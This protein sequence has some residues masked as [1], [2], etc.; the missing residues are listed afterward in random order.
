MTLERRDI[1]KGASVGALGSMA[2]AAL[3][4][5]AKADVSSGA[6][7]RV[8]FNPD[9]LRQ[10]TMALLKLT[11][12]LGNET[13]R[14]WFTGKVYAYF[15]GAPV[16][17]LFYLDGFYLDR[18]EARE[19]GTRFSTRFEITLKRDL[20]S[21]ELLEQWDNPFTGR[22]DSVINSVGGPQFKIY[23]DWGFALPERARTANNPLLLDWM[24]M[25][26]DAWV[27]WDSFLRFTN[28]LQ[29]EEYPLE[30]SGE[31]L[32]LVNLT[33]FKG[34]LSDIEDP[35]ML[36]APGV[37][38]WNAV[39]GWQPWMRMGQK[40]GTLIYKAI[41]VKLDSFSQL[42]EPVFAAAEKA[43]PGHLSEQV[44]WQEGNYQWFDRTGAKW[45]DFIQ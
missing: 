44:P 17:E 36:N 6:R 16:Q 9:D 1:L 8:P 15:P 21:G 26:D 2:T 34:R 13:I 37:M 40:P 12:S 33:N 23:N 20:E 32:D 18:Y 4:T 14:K 24:I 42:P 27:T 22:T 7:R 11:G 30:S 5:Q 39:S 28:P 31:M 43:F 29:P 45:E 35:E 41:G 3:A 19:D 10:S 38:F 25:G